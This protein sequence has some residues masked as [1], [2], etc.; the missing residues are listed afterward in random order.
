MEVAP[1]LDAAAVLFFFSVAGSRFVLHPGTAV[2]LPVAPFQ[3]GVPYNAHVVTVL[4][5]RNP[6]S[7]LTIPKEETY[8]FD[9]QK[10]PRTDVI[11]RFHQLAHDDKDAPLL[12]RAGADIDYGQVLDL[13]IHAQAA[14]LSRVVLA[15]RADDTATPP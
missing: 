13:C 3:D 10:M 2:N 5:D 1:W 6:E 7:D 11:D 14:G 15:T 12:I 4:G 9:G 8:F